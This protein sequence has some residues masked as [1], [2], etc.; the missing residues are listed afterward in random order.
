MFY[1]GVCADDAADVIDSSHGR[2]SASNRAPSHAR[3]HTVA[4]PGRRLLGDIDCVENFSRDC[5]KSAFL[6]RGDQDRAVHSALLSD[7]AESAFRKMNSG[8]ESEQITCDV[9][10]LQI[11]MANYRDG[12]QV[13]RPIR[14]K[15]VAVVLRHPMD[16]RS[17]HIHTCYPM[18]WT[19]N[20]KIWIG[21]NQLQW[22]LNFSDSS[23]IS[24]DINRMQT[25]RVT[26]W[27]QQLLDTVRRRSGQFNPRSNSTNRIEAAVVLKF[28]STSRWQ[29][30]SAPNYS[31]SLHP[32]T[33]TNDTHLITKTSWRSS[34]TDSRQSWNNQRRYPL[35]KVWFHE[36]L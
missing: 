26:E 23:T 4:P 29:L 20:V 3:G 8:S 18:G 31:S 34:K 1:D 22:L 28:A 2:P 33:S 5:M 10:H 15:Y 16:D 6:S 7:A 35:L 30:P 36:F 25:S 24:T 32:P 14:V 11:M 17:I 12:L 27:V 9:R 13:T 19:A 21:Q